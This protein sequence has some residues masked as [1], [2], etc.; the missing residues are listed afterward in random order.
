M[1]RTYLETD[2][3]TLLI[4]GIELTAKDLGIGT[5][6]TVL[7]SSEMGVAGQSWQRVLRLV[8]AV[9]G[10]DYV[11]GHGAARYL[12]HIAFMA[13][14][15]SVSYMDYGLGRWLRG[16]RQATPHQSILDLIAWTGSGAVDYLKP[17]T[18]PWRDFVA[19]QAR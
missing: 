16:G 19:K 1:D 17:A 4:A 11:T 14:G 3:P 12:D 10:T 2:L 8:Q 15:V 5:H 9:G 13:A 18:V 7:R 6:R